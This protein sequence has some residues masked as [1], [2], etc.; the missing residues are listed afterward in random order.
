MISQKTRKM[1]VT[2]RRPFQP[3]L[4]ENLQRQNLPKMPSS[5]AAGP[6]ELSKFLT[7]NVMRIKVELKFTVLFMLIYLLYLI[8][9][10]I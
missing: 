5:V 10:Y 1:T 4:R 9:H 2:L 6:K 8:L 7:E 3:F